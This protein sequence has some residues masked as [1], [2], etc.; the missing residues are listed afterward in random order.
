MSASPDGYTRPVVGI[1]GQ[2]PCP[3]ID[4]NKG[5]RLVVQV[6][7]NLGNESTSLHWHG[8]GQYGTNHMDG[9]SGTTQ[10]PVPPGSNF[11]YDFQVHLLSR[12]K[13]RNILT[14]QG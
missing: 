12:H 1:N 2:W 9:T 10:C 11:T 3:Q 4:L 6:Y 5:D 7:N 8:F 14:Y 13:Q